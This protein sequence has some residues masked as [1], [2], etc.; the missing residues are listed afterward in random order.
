MEFVRFSPWF[1][2]PRV[3]VPE[4]TPH[5][6]NTTHPSTNWNSTYF[7]E[8]MKDFQSAVC[9]P[10]ASEGKCTHSVVQQLST[11]PSWM[12]IGGDDEPLPTYPWNTTNPFNAYAAGNA[13]V[14]KTC[15]Q[16]ARSVPDAANKGGSVSL[17]IVYPTYSS[18]LGRQVLRPPCRLVHGWGIP[19]RMRALPP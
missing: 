13:L 14:D 19:R 4:L 12:Y 8:V 9:G 1:A 15:G 3:V 5:V 18:S 10:L 7:D 17:V 2:N 16:M 11:M 6:C